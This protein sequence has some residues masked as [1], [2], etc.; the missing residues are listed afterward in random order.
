MER[1]IT[2]SFEKAS[3]GKGREVVSDDVFYSWKRLAD[4]ELSTKNWWSL[5]DTI[6]G[7]DDYREQQNAADTFDYDA[8]VEGIQKI[9][10]HEFKIQLTAAT[11]RFRWTLAMFQFSIVRA[12]PLKNMIR[13]SP[14]TPLVQVRSLSRKAIGLGQEHEVQAQPNLPR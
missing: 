5:K 13:N 3:G 11:P 12:T 2:S 6:V 9:N 1:L 8:P 10:D 4:T 14:S 7:L